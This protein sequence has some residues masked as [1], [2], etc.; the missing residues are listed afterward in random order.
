VAKPVVSTGPGNLVSSPNIP[1]THKHS[2]VLTPSETSGIFSLAEEEL[3]V[4][5]FKL[6]QRTLSETDVLH[7][8]SLAGE[9]SNPLGIPFSLG[10]DGNNAL[11]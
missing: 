4:L 6:W 8:A 9:G 5:E 7:L 10:L 3:K 11:G 2:R 1:P